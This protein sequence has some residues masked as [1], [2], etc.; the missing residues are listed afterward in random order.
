MIDTHAHLNFKAFEKD[1]SEV[2]ERCFEN[3]IK[4]IINVGAKLDTSQR[5]IELAHQF[6]NLYAAVGLHPIHV[7]DEEFDIENYCRLISDKKVVAIGEIGLDLS[8]I[9]I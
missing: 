8:L 5:A 4:A 3:G 6:D 7:N 1:L 2:V 9:H